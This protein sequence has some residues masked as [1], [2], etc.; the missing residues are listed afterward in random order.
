[1]ATYP[2]K[3]VLVVDDDII[4]ASVLEGA[5]LEMGVHVILAFDGFD[6]MRKLDQCNP[7]LVFMDVHMPFFD[8]LEVIRKIRNKGI[9]IP[10]ISLSASTML[11]EREGSFMA[12]ANG[13]LAKPITKDELDRVL[14]ESFTSSQGRAES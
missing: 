8:G 3:S 5:L 10:I 9:S 4:N 6:A 14:R 12:G 13:F 7:D 1:M 2:G 11:N